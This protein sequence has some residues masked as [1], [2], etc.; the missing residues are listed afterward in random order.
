MKFYTSIQQY[1]NVILERYIE[2]GEHKQR[3]VPYQPTL[4]VPTVKQS[5]FKTITG[6]VVEPRGFNSIKEARDFIQARDKVSNDPVYGMQQFAYAY[7]NEEYPTRDFDFSQLNIFNFDIETRSDEGFPNI[8]TANMDIL[9]IAVRCNGQSYI[10]GCQEYKT[11]GEDIYIKCASEA[12]LL[13]KFI[14]LWKDLDPD[15]VTGWNIE[16]FDIPY[17]CNRIERVLSKEA[18][19]ELSPFKLV[20]DRFFGRPSEGEQPEAKEIYGVT[21][22]DYLSLYRKFTY[23]QQESYALDYIGEAELG[24]K[25]LDY[26]EYGTLNELYKNDYQKF[27]DYN[28]RDVVL[29]EKLDD[30]MKLLEQACTIAYD[31][32]VNLIDSLTSVRMWDVIIHN[33]LMEKNIVVPP[34]QFGE[35]ENQ[36][37]GAYVK[38]PQVG[39]HNWVVSFDLNSLY[40]H[41]IMQYNISPETYVRHIGQ[42]PTADEII[43]GLFDNENIKE[44]M[45]KHNVSVCGSGAMYTKDFQ[46]FLPKLMET[47]Y[48]DRVKWKTRMIEAQKKYQKNKTK[49]LEYEIA[50]CNNM[51]MA[52]KIQ[53]NS[54][55]GALGNQYFRFFDTKYAESITL[56]G[57][58]SIKWM[59]VKINQF[60]NK[61]LKTEKV[62]YVVAVDTDSLYVVL[63]TLVGQ[64]GIDTNDTNK[65]INFLDKVASEVLEPF[66]D[67]GYREL[68]NY[69]G[70]YEQKMVMKREAIADKGIWTGKKHYILN[71]YDNEGVRYQE[72]KLKMMGI[73]SVRSSTPGVVRKAIKEALDVLMKDGEMALREYVNDFEKLFNAMPYEDVAFPR[74]CRYMRKWSDASDIYKKGTPIHVRGALLYNKVVKEKKLDRKYNEIH[75]GDKIKFCYMKLPNP[76]RENVFAVPTVL[77]PELGMENYIDYEKQFEKSFKDPLNHICEAVGWSIDKQATLDQFFV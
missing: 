50:K 9:S 3:E 46:G 48:N 57:Q 65:V 77:P 66:I 24:E 32:G 21:I 17:V 54:A 76:M 26:S 27:L 45:K 74:G 7:I 38:D 56:S 31:A 20:R 19:N 59:E 33:F 52:K 42:R 35:K 10:L 14:Q 70:A 62:D 15:I 58:L 68:A 11:S 44:F 43:A 64:S 29:V 16:T 23:I 40:P 30:K 2:D 34:K 53:L 55:Y 47:M 51:Q 4:F 8:Q 1:N 73:E 60:L 63:D 67:K 61:K 39:L 25:K 41:L 37:E 75:E 28:I 6:E 49:E 13:H 71:V 72:P 5:P 12:D 36:V 69:V 18:V 22:F